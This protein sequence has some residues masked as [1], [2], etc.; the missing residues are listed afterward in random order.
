MGK[1]S[2]VY[3]SKAKNN[4]VNSLLKAWIHQQAAV[5]APV[6][7]DIMTAKMN[8][9]NLD[10]FSTQLDEEDKKDIAKKFA[11]VDKDG[12][13][14]LKEK[15]VRELIQAFNLEHKKRH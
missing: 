5:K 14:H 6:N 7:L 12:D 15:E 10:I 8:A 3:K 9:I 11:T 1:K 13:G 4:I 2:S